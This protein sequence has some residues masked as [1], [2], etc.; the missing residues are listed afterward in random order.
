MIDYASTTPSRTPWSKRILWLVLFLLVMLAG[1]AALSRLGNATLLIV[2][3]ISDTISNDDKSGKQLSIADDPEYALPTNSNDRLDV[4]ILG[5]RGKEDVENGGLLTDTVLLLSIDKSSGRASLV[6]IPRDLTIRI[7][8]D[9]VGKINTLYAH[10]GVSETKKMY[11]RILGVGIDN[12]VVADFDAFVSVVDT[13]GG[14]TVTLDKPFQE[15]QQWGFPFSLPAGKN[16]LNGQQALYYSRSRYSSSDFDRSRRQ[17][18]VLMAIKDKATSL[19]L[20]DEPIKAL[21]LITEIRKHI[22][23]DLNIFDL[24]TIKDILLQQ[25]KLATIRR[26]QLT[27]ENVLYETKVNGVYELLPRDATLKHIKDFIVSI[28]GAQ[29]LLPTPDILPASPSAAT[30]LPTTMP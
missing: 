13:L 23:T 17:M 22:N 30:L 25:K 5:I 10:Y 9:R 7:T 14:I 4:L 26:Y 6:S 21:S 2:N 15:S 19:S 12:I 3:R 18:Q 1:R 16:N 27:T 28:T 20:L 8:D 11:S 24:G 29:P